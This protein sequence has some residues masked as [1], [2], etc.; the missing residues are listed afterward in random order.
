MNSKDFYE[1]NEAYIKEI[2]CWVRDWIQLYRKYA[3]VLDEKGRL[4]QL[5]GSITFGNDLELSLEGQMTAEEQKQYKL[6]TNLLKNNRKQI[7]KKARNSFVHGIA[8]PLEFLFQAFGLTEA[9]KF[10]ILM[11][12]SIEYDKTMGRLFGLLQDNYKEIFPTLDLCMKIYSAYEEERFQYR[13]ELLIHKNGFQLL[14]QESLEN[15]RTPI[16]VHKRVLCF[17]DN[18]EESDQE[19][20]GICNLLLEEY[21]PEYSPERKE[22]LKLLAQAA[23]R[24]ETRNVCYVHGPQGAGRCRLVRQVT[25]SAK[26]PL[27]IIDTKLLYY[28]KENIDS[29]LRSILRELIIRNAVPCCIHGEI[30]VAGEEDSEATKTQK[31]LFTGKLIRNLIV[32][33]SC[34]FI[35]SLKKWEGNWFWNETAKTDWEIPFPSMKEQITLWTRLLKK[36]EEQ[37]LLSEDVW[38]QKLGVRFSLT[39]GQMIEALK[40]T[41]DW[42]KARNKKKIDKE[43]LYKFCRQQ[44]VMDLGNHVVK[45]ETH[46]QWEDLV[47]PHRQKEALKSACN[48]VEFSHQ[49]Y[50]TWSFGKKI[51]YGRGVSMLFYGPPGTGKTM[52]A[53]VMA[54]QLSMEL[55]KVDLSSI[56][57]KYI[58]ETEKNLGKIFEQIKKSRSILFFDEAD[59]LFGK[60]T[61]VKDSH[62]RYANAE[63]AYLLQR[64]EEYQGIVI[65]A[66]NYIQNFDE[67]FKRRIKFMIEF[68][69]PLASYRKNLWQ[70]VFPEEA[71]VGELDYEYLAEQFELSGSSIRNI[72]T[73]A[74][75]LAAGAGEKIGMK[76]V[77]IA[78]RE[79]L[80]KCGKSMP[81]ESFGEYFWLLEEGRI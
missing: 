72:G 24:K 35:T 2:L 7:E 62:D 70:T 10:C 15:S 80:I 33:G 18:F 61:E 78:L 68:P 57:S 12:L 42:C 45:V 30:L 11:A 14:L 73:A 26:K 64:M 3:V 9:G 50:D 60:R 52:G 23:W 43:I 27:L 6:R 36:S 13:T 22:Q 41:E 28:E 56:M 20:E 67:A 39:I 4:K 32:Q 46:Y 37:G 21:Q 65:M 54:N 66:T 38:P 31:Q 17:L 81:L 59:A 63:T 40:R 77:L 69:F 79:E 16:K 76:Q 71:P 29:L 58:G 53:Q 5:K 34:L 75:F 48:Q 8:I 19:L 47:L 25:A 55:Y 1:S 51:A 74:A 49:I 44:I